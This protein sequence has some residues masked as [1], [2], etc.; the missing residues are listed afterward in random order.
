M[1]SFFQI[2]L[3]Q[4]EHSTYLFIMFSFTS[5]ILS[6]SFVKKENVLHEKCFN[7]QKSF[8]LKNVEIVNLSRSGKSK[9]ELT[10]KFIFLDD[11]MF[12]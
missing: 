11:I 10:P 12:L 4:I 3:I 1:F 9:F 5:R 8:W 6:L 7:A 2:D